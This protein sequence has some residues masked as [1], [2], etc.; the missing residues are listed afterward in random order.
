[1]IPQSGGRDFLANSSFHVFQ[2][3]HVAGKSEIDTSV[4]N[5]NS[6]GVSKETV[7]G[8]MSVMT[9]G[10][11][12]VFI[13]FMTLRGMLHVKVNVFQKTM[14]LIFFVQNHLFLSGGQIREAFIFV[15]YRI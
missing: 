3:A 15:E 10:S 6:I 14:I 8:R 11:F 9:V 7:W 12:Q 4:Q 13:N 5:S 2:V 1:M